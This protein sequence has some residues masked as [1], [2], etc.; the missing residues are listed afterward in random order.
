[1]PLARTGPIRCGTSSGLQFSDQALV[2]DGLNAKPN[3]FLTINDA[4]PTEDQ[5]LMVSAAGVTD[6]NNVSP[7]NLTGAI[8]GPIS[9]FWQSEVRPGVFEDILIENAGGEVARATGL[10]FTP[11]DLEVGRA[12]RVRAVY[13]DAN[14]VL[15]EVYLDTDGD[16]DDE[17]RGPHRRRLPMSTMR[18]SARS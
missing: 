3:G 11:G 15:E 17:S 18:R 7:T 4:T 10:T 6:A 2:F 5:L 12:L 13:K 16:P 14:D 1:M 9:Y 8:T